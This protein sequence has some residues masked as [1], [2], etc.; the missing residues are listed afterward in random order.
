[1]SDKTGFEKFMEKQVGDT[2]Q[3]RPKSNT[4]PVRQAEEEKETPARTAPVEEPAKKV[5]RGRPRKDP[6][7]KQKLVTLNFLV[8]EEM[9]QL[10]EQMKYRTHKTTVKGVIMEALDLLFD[11]Y[12]VER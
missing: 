12:G 1:M 10:L 6:E 7:S 9:K 4:R 3:I 2:V 5:G 11:K 8:D